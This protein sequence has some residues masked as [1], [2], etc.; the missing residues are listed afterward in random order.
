MLPAISW[1][2]LLVVTEWQVVLLAVTEGQVVLLVVTE[3]QVVLLVVTEWQMV[4]LAVT[5]WQMVLLVVTEWLE[6][7]HSPCMLLRI[8]NGN[9]ILAPY[10]VQPE[11]RARIVKT[12]PLGLISNT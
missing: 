1:M 8:D 7:R 12:Q 2:V 4:L 9:L 5:E 6:K 11:L 3:W 10:I